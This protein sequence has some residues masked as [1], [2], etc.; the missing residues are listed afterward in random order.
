[1]HPAP[2]PPGRDLDLLV[3]GEVNP[4]V[5]VRAADPVPAFGQVERLVDAIELV[6]GS[7]SAILACGAARLGLRTAFAG[8]VGDDALGRFMLEA[9]RARGVDPAA[10]R[11]DP[12]VPTGASVILSGAGDRAILTAPG[13]MR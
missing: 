10:I 9:L 5:V 7:S 4:D 12:A 13:R 11:V 8:V 1:M 2:P 6:V 3:V